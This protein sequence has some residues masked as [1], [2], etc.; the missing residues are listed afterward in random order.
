M[1]NQKEKNSTPTY[2]NANPNKEYS[3]LYIS[4]GKDETIMS[5]GDELITDGDISNMVHRYKE[6][7]NFYRRGSVIIE[8][9]NA[10]YVIVQSI[11]N[12]KINYAE[13]Y[14]TI[15]EEAKIS[16]LNE[17]A[18][19]ETNSN[20]ELLTTRHPYVRKIKL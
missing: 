19:E 14:T 12:K 17:I 5:M 7:D 16:K 13:V 20:Q 4:S 15:E 3:I 2:F 18:F 8:I 6:D 11:S 10:S 9:K 1:E